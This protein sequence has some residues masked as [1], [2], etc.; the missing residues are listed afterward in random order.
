MSI[1]IQK[2]KQKRSFRENYM[3]EKAAVAANDGNFFQGT[4]GLKMFRIT[5][6]F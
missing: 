4:T 3:T 1:T 2:Q 5:G 6:C